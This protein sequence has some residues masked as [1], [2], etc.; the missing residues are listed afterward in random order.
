MRKITRIIL[1]FSLLLIL[2]LWSVPTTFAQSTTDGTQIK[3][4]QVDNSKF[5]QVTVYVSVT[6]AAGEPVGV[7]PST[8]QIS[9]NGQVMQ[10]DQCEPAASKAAWPANDHAGHRYFR[11]HECQRQAG[12]RQ[13]C[14]KGLC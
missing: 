13:S 2:M 6:N 3:I 11:Q 7:D 5:P 1:T 9:E 14:R 10:P 4:T 12:W 8:I